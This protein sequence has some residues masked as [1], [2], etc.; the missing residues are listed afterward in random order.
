MNEMDAVRAKTGKTATRMVLVNWG[1]FEQPDTV[2]LTD[3]SMFV[4]TNGS[5][6]T[7]SMDA[8]AFCLY[9]ISDFN[10]SAKKNGEQK[11][12]RRT[13]PELLHGST[14]DPDTPYLRP[15][16]VIS[17][18][19]IEF[20]DHKSGRYFLCGQVTES[21]DIRTYKTWRFVIDDC[22]LEEFRFRSDD[23]LEIYSRSRCMCKGLPVRL[24]IFQEK[25]NGLKQIARAL[26]IQ[27]NYTKIANIVKKMMALNPEA[28]VSR[29]IAE[30][31][32]EIK[33]GQGDILKSLRTMQDNYT[34]AASELD[35][36]SRER[37][38][39]KAA[40][41]AAKA[42]SAQKELHTLEK[43]KFA[44]K[45]LYQA[46]DN[47]SVL[48]KNREAKKAELRIKK[49]EARKADKQWRDASEACQKAERS[50]GLSDINAIKENKERKL[51]ESRD[52]ERALIEKENDLCRFKTSAR[53]A[54]AVFGN[55]PEA[56]KLT[57]GLADFS[58][59]NGRAVF[60]GI[61]KFK[62]DRIE[63]LRQE[64]YDTERARRELSEKLSEMR[65]ELEQLKADT[66]V[67]P[68][69]YEN[70]RKKIQSY[71]KSRGLD[72]PVK[73]AVE[74]VREIKDP[75]WQRAIESHLRNNR[76]CL[77]IPAEHEDAAF[78]FVKKERIQ[79]ASIFMSSIPM[80][81]EAKEG[82]AASM[83]DIVN[84]DAKKFFVRVLGS[85][86]LA[87][88]E[89]DVKNFAREN[90]A[91]ITRDGTRSS[92]FARSLNRPVDVLYIGKDAVARR[93]A[94]LSEEYRAKSLDEAKLVRKSKNTGEKISALNG[95][96]FDYGKYDFDASSKLAAVREMIAKEMK[97]LDEFNAE[98]A[99]IR[100]EY[101]KMEEERDRLFALRDSANNEKVR[102]EKDIEDFGGAI[103]KKKEELDATKKDYDRLCSENPD[104]EYR[105]T[106]DAAKIGGK[107]PFHNVSMASVADA[108]QKESD[109][110]NEMVYR[111][112]RYLELR[113][114]TN[115]ELKT[116]ADAINGLRKTYNELSNVRFVECDEAVRKQKERLRRS[117]IQ[118][119]IAKIGE[120]IENAQREKN[121]RNR[122]LDKLNF[123]QQKYRFVIDRNE[124]GNMGLF[125]R[126][127]DELRGAMS[128]ENLVSM[129]DSNVGLNAAVM[130]YLDIILNEEDSSVYTDY[131]N[132]LKCD[133]EILEEQKHMKYRL[134][135]KQSKSSNGEQ[136]TPYLI[137]LIASLSTLF[138]DDNAAKLCLM[139]EAFAAW[140]ADRIE[141]M[142]GYF[143]DNGFQVIFGAPDKQYN[144]LGKYMTSFITCIKASENP[145]SFFCDGRELL[146]GGSE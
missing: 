132:Y 42:Y 62:N 131:R 8:V 141:R 45:S 51:R 103:S 78:E 117:L 134:T 71:F 80:S 28:N 81:N 24:D 35:R 54:L 38:S 121:R 111:Q 133:M 99:D 29:F 122:T 52:E 75:S 58:G 16:E 105:V 94:A 25:G 41:D 21:R 124:E 91:S 113:G 30:S 55:D 44:Y 84:N 135:T 59:E 14:L 46:K 19:I 32:L 13:L 119:F 33:E 125:Y 12:D 101:A 56:V 123:G 83:L 104:Y 107:N 10:A 17:W 11:K 72:V 146:D 36:V 138:H 73:F 120:Q 47:I 61:E 128:P 70:A 127:Y 140:D 142:I 22:R 37:D 143:K 112:R 87:D 26:G 82:T 126:I 98:T 74:L 39:L 100:A 115:V 90:K 64:K 9:G 48:E 57:R 20:I 69:A 53:N 2:N 93:I 92:G 7:M 76:F 67:F 106:D 49:E 85:V 6:K 95:L 63:A 68:S 102:V 1:P 43:M 66:L 77:I 3:L 23:G 60:S 31:I 130:E 108:G 50:L 144:T 4:G 18:C 88:T 65:N 86:W 137:I 114:E 89:Q 27:G 34:A 136:Q 116:G 79:N 5:G 145:Y 40:D 109:A 15:G 96:Y 129:L 118:E 110:Y 139:D 97:D